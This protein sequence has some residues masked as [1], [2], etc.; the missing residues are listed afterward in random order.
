MHKFITMAENCHVIILIIF[1]HHYNL[2]LARALLS[3]WLFILTASQFQF[4]VLGG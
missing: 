2:E 4:W 3:K 1:W